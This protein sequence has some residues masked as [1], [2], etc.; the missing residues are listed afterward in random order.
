MRRQRIPFSPPMTVLPLPYVIQP[1]TVKFEARLIRWLNGEPFFNEGSVS[2][3][4]RPPEYSPPGQEESDVCRK[5]VLEQVLPLFLGLTKALRVDTYSLQQLIDPH[6]P[7]WAI[8]DDLRLRPVFTRKGALVAWATLMLFGMLEQ[9]RLSLLGQCKCDCGKLVLMWRNDRQFATPACRVRYHQS[10]EDFKRKRN[11][12]ARKT[13]QLH[14]QSKA[15]TKRSKAI[16]NLRVKTE[17]PIKP[18]H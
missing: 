16:E 2:L 9:G 14:R 12:E 11:E 1:Q 18:I 15:F 17:K 7:S 10:S 3:R 6:K 13:R 8:S 4:R 5:E